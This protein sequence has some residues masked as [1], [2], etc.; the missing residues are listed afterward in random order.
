MTRLKKN[1]VVLGGGSWGTALAHV[2]AKAQQ[3]V[4]MLVRDATIAQAI[5]SE[6]KHP[7]YVQNLLLDP[8]L[9]ATNDENILQEAHVVVVA[10]PFQSIAESLPKFAHLIREDAIIINASK[11]LDVQTASPLSASIHAL[12]PS[13]KGVYAMLSGPSFAREVI[14]GQPTAVVLACKDADTGAFLREDCSSARFRCYS[15]TDVLGVELGGALKNVLAIAAGAAAGLGLKDNASAALI[16]RG[17]A[18]ISRIGVSLGAQAMTFMGLSGLGDLMLT[19]MGDLSRNRQVG[20]RLAQGESLED[21][22]QSLGMVAEG[23]KTTQ[24]LYTLTQKKGLSSPITAS[25]YALIQ[26]NDPKKSIQ[27]LMTRSLKE[28]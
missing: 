25:V 27:K 15:S 18:E 13:W 22:V 6:H 14:E 9:L 4:H 24:A 11:G 28:E 23:V 2:L 16:T 17:I 20:F 21:I 10:I 19:C 1:F 7:K 12:L 5:N 26:G 3:N 8:N